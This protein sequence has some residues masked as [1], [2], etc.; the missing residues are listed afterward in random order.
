MDSNIQNSLGGSE[1]QSVTDALGSLEL[2]R[3]WR[4]YALA[5][6]YMGG[7]AYFN[8]HGIGF[9]QIQELG[10]NQK[11]TWKRGQLGIRDAFSYQPEGNFGSAYG[12]VATSGAALNG[13][14]VF[15]G[16][17]ALG[18]LGQVPRIM[19]ISTVDVVENLTPKSAITAA[20]GYGLVH[21]LG[22]EAPNFSFIGNSQTTVEVG[23]DRVLGLH[24][25]GALVF[26]YQKF[27][28]ST[29]LDFDSEVVQ[30][31][32][33]HRISGRMDFLIA[34]GPQFIQINLPAVAF[35][36]NPSF[37]NPPSAPC[38]A[39][40]G[41]VVNL[42]ESCPATSDFRITAAG[43]AMLRYQFTK[44]GLDAGYNHYTTSGSGFFAGAE[45]DVAHL[46]ATRPL[47]RAWTAF[48]DLGFSRNSRILPTTCTNSSAS[49][50]PGVN[51]NTY[52]YVFAGFGL[53]RTLSRSLRGFMSYQ[54]ND[55]ILG[56]SYCGTVNLCNRTSQRQIGTIGLDWTPR[57]IRLD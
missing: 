38:T 3:L 27:N 1:P 31:M 45:S 33:G 40:S 17:S 18:E 22:N 55:L 8:V 2:Q 13:Q 53:H 10:V 11:I 42:L 37:P 39:A 48:T 50:C 20:A 43:R 6:D 26:G 29:G 34:A 36:A 23:Y 9:K 24:D 52:E 15:F 30:L 19:N 14:G 12:S 49:S 54:F 7:V 5:A 35:E 56:T 32:W 16:G 25:Q 4:Y 44:V 41:P 51:A 28:F 21:F 57:P 46:T 47:R